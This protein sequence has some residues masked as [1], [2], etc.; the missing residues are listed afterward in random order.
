MEKLYGHDVIEKTE[1]FDVRGVDRYT[2][3]PLAE[4]MYKKTDDGKIYQTD[5]WQC[6]NRPDI[7]THTRLMYDIDEYNKQIKKHLY[8]IQK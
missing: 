7:Y 6:S 1:W 4:R 2:D 5:R 8:F 3:Y